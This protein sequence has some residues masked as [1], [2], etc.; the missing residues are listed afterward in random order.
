MAG[1]DDRRPNRVETVGSFAICCGAPCAAGSVAAPMVVSYLLPVCE[2]WP[3]NNQS[4]SGPR[5]RRPQICNDLDASSNGRQQLQH[6]Q[7]EQ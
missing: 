2:S 5:G 3:E 1:E 4:M 6:A 7:I